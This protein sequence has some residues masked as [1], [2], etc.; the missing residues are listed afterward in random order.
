MNYLNKD[1]DDALERDGVREFFLT[2]YAS[3]RQD[4]PLDVAET[5][6]DYMV[7]RD[8]DH[9]GALLLSEIEDLIERNLPEEELKHLIVDKWMSQFGPSKVGS[10]QQLLVNIRDYIRSR[11]ASPHKPDAS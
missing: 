10:L 3:P 11:Q 9:D 5:V 1:I 4:N 8:D 2:Y 6:D 7:S